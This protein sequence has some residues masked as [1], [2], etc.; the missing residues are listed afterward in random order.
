MQFGSSR[1][2]CG[3]SNGHDRPTGN[4]TPTAAKV[5]EPAGDYQ[6]R[7]YREILVLG[8]NT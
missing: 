6:D 1:V 2:L 5:Q 3:Q 4:P 8:G 7:E